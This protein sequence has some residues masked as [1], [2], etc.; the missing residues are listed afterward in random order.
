[1]LDQVNTIPFFTPLYY[2]GRKIAFFHQLCEK[3]W[4]YEM[5][6]PLSLLGYI[7]EKLYLRLYRRI[8]SLVV[9]ASTKKN[10]ESYGFSEVF[11]MKDCID[12]K[13]LDKVPLKE[14]SLIYVGRLKKSK[15]VHDIIKAFSIVNKE[16][17]CKLHIVGKGDKS[18]EK[19]L[20]G[21]KSITFHGFLPKEK[22][23]EL[24]SKAKAILVASVKE[25]WG[26]IVVEANAMGT[27]AIVYDVDGL[28]DSVKD[29]ETG[30]VTKESPE[31]M[32]KAII[33]FLKDKELQERLSINALEY[34]RGFDWDESAS[35]VLRWVEGVV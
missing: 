26:L 25:G 16:I 30:I 17:S 21:G 3:I 20:K 24:M 13:P 34:S 31:A 2:K 12:F 29:G 10:L 32:A 1:V 14:D 19:G 15:R 28:R 27:P 4:F 18:Y 8:P 35:E 11:I 22:R 23:N 9:S 5:K 7:S 33:S 6:F